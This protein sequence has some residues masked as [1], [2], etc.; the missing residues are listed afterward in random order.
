MDNLPTFLWIEPTNHCNLRCIMCP[1]G[2]GKVDIEKGYM[3][4][5]FFERII[6]DIKDFASAV[7]LA[8]SGESMLHP[9][10]FDMV[11]Y[12]KKNS[13]KTLLN[14]NATLIH[15]EKAEQ[16][17]ESGIDNISFAFDGFEKSGYEKARVGASYQKTLDNILYFLRLKKARRAKSP[18]TILS[19]LMLGI[20]NCS[21]AEKEMF[22]AQFTGL[23]DEVRLREV[24]T[25]GKTFN[26]TEQFSFRQN[27][28]LYPPC[29]RLWST[30][31]ITWNG[32]VVPCIY[33][34]NHE[35]TIGN[36]RNNR[37]TQ[38]WNNKRMLDLRRSMLKGEY[39]RLSP[40]CENCIVLGTPP[41]LK[42]P[43][44]LR[45]T[46]SDAMTNV[47][48][49]RFEKMAI[50]FANKLSNGQFTSRTINIK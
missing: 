12:A 41:I 14:T 46:I 15:R 22:L 34:A 23:V 11:R 38:V 47:L 5:G 2:A 17:L 35:Y 40:I 18:Y 32:D 33:N 9:Q 28:I 20:D 16:L 45:L 49:Y 31:V 21:D 37:F 43:S 25:W 29:S 27:R 4:Y 48:G 1:S 39:L 30:A 6:D 10:F 24:S 13:I 19:I 42:I 44:G 7:T 8:V 50:S 36:L 26:K 3:D